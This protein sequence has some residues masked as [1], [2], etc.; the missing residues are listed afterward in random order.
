MG[1]GLGLAAG[2]L[3]DHVLAQANVLGHGG[4]HQ[5]IEAREPAHLQD[6]RRKAEV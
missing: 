4:V 2:W 1:Q 3:E 5:A 6:G